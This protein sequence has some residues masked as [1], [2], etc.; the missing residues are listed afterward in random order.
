M[1]IGDVKN[2]AEKALLLKACSL[3]TSTTLASESP[4]VTS[5]LLL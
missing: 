5:P 2:L 3:L 1:C 4:H